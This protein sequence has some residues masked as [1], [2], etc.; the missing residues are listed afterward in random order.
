MVDLSSKGRDQEEY[1]RTL[2]DLQKLLWDIN[3]E[4][5]RPSL[6]LTTDTLSPLFQL[7]KATLANFPGHIRE[8]LL[9]SKLL[10]FASLHASVFPKIILSSPL[11][12]AVTIFTDASGSGTAA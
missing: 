6:K 5:L 4:R 11:L 3:L 1:L 9:H 8:H 7:L 2:N 10:Q 12:E